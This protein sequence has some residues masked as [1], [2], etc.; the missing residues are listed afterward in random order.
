MEAVRSFTL[1]W[2]D[3]HPP[4]SYS[5]RPPTICYMHVCRYQLGYRKALK[6]GL[7]V[8][9]VSKRNRL[10]SGLFCISKDSSIAL[11]AF[12]N[13]DHAGCQDTRRSTSAGECEVYAGES[14]PMADEV[15]ELVVYQIL[16]R[17][18]CVLRI[19]GLYTSRLLDAA[20]K[21]VLNLLRKDCMV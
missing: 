9:S 19:S 8:L 3:R 18:N 17:V 2:Y 10:H 21:K 14:E 7:K 13:A 20:C 15:D 4:L 12:A 16:E 11:T 1:S 5:S 6:C